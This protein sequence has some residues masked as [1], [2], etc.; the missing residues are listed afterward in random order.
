MSRN[1]HPTAVHFGIRNHLERKGNVVTQ[2][3]P[4]ED[5]TGVLAHYQDSTTFPSI[6]AA[7]HFMRTGS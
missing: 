5:R 1:K 4:K 2:T 6:N 3:T 7:K